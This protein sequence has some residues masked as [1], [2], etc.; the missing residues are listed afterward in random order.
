[1]SE[2][3]PDA[4]IWDSHAD[5]YGKPLF[6]SLFALAW[7]DEYPV[8]VLSYSSC[9]RTLLRQLVIETALSPGDTLVDLGCGIG[10]VALWFAREL[11]VNAIGVDWS[12]RAIEIA[13]QRQSEWSIQGAVAFAQGS[14]SETG[15]PPDS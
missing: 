5:R 2:T 11:N 10:G 1:M 4:T 15:L 8:D 7:G 14:F 3:P 13:R 6:W 9:T 12:R